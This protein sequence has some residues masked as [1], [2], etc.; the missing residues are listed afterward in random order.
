MLSSLN[1]DEVDAK[2]RPTSSWERCLEV[3]RKRKPITQQHCLGRK[4]KI[5]SATSRHENWLR[6]MVR[7]WNL[8]CRWKKLSKR[9]RRIRATRREGSANQV[10]SMVNRYSCLFSYLTCWHLWAHTVRNCFEKVEGLELETGLTLKSRQT[11]CR[12]RR[13]FHWAE[14]EIIESVHGNE[15]TEI[16]PSRG[17][18]FASIRDI[19]ILLVNLNKAE[20]NQFYPTI[21]RRNALNFAR[22]RG[23]RDRWSPREFFASR[24]GVM[25][26]QTSIGN[27]QSTVNDDLIPVVIFGQADPNPPQNRQGSSTSKRE[28]KT[29]NLTFNFKPSRKRLVGTTK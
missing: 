12:W 18:Y 17:D 5:R 13:S 2:S 3:Y 4:R 11:K 14:F 28:G 23:L 19:H 26:S 15:D 22:N 8:F 7:M 25:D 24:Q 10:R 20:W 6:D 27:M 29:Y 21:Y 9:K 16:H 1:K